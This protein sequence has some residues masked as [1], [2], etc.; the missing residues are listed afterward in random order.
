MKSNIAGAFLTSAFCWAV[1]LPGQAAKHYE[2]YYLPA[3][4]PD[5][6]AAIG[7]PPAAGTSE[8]LRDAEAV[9]LAEKTRTSAEVTQAQNDDA[10]EDIFLYSTVLGPPSMRLH[11]PSWQP[12]LPTCVTMLA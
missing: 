8:A 3:V 1:L 10:Q 5:Y 12:C 9:R 7:P 11:F 2:P 6:A 4:R